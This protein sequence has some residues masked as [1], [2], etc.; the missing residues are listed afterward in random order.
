MMG[1]D[2]YFR[3]GITHK[4]CQDYAFA[5]SNYVILSDGCSGEQD[6]DFGSRLLVRAAAQQIQNFHLMCPQAF[7]HRTLSTAAIACRTI[8]LPDSSLCA[9]LLF[10]IRNEN[11][12]RYCIV[13]DGAVAI[14]FKDGTTKIVRVTAHNNMPFYLRYCLSEESWEIYKKVVGFKYSISETLMQSD[15]VCASE[16]QDVVVVPEKLNAQFVGGAVAASEVEA[17][18]VISDGV[19]QF[20]HPAMNGTAIQNFPV[21]GNEIIH[22]AMA[23]KSY[24]GEFVNRRMNRAFKTFEKSGWQNIDDFSIAVIAG[25]NT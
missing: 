10:A 18:A 13:G 2:A 9:T 5:G 11:Y 1:T 19:D 17:L 20:I 3:M 21:N 12:L 24:T 14:K 15:G 4:V 8:G 25:E 16:T 23:F 22:E 6:S 7:F